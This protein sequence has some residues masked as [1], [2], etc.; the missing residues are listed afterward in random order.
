[1]SAISDTTRR[2]GWYYGW[3][4]VAVCVL[5]QV[6]ANGLAINSLSLFLRDWAAELHTQIS[7]LL[8]AMLALAFVTAGAA[9]VIGA[10]ADRYPSRLLFGAGLAGVAAFCLGV[11]LASEVWHI[12][13]LY[14]LVYPVAL[15]LSA[16]IPANAVVSRWFVKRLGLALGITAFGSGV[17]GVVLPPLIAALMPALG[18][19]AIWQV[20]AALVAFVV[21]PIAL[22]VL[23]ERPTQQ[24]GL[25]YVAGGAAHVRHG[26]GHGHGAGATAGDGLRWTD[27]LKRRNFWLLA[28][29]LVPVVAAYG[30]IHQN[31]APIAASHGFGQRYAGMLLSVF[32][33]SYIASTVLMGMASD[34]FGNRIPLAGL[35]A[36]VAA[37]AAMLGFADT[38]PALIV[39]AV[40]VGFG[41]GLW[42]LLP[43]A[44]AV[45]FG[46]VGVGRAFG[47][48]MLF[49]PIN[50]AMSLMIAK[51]KEGTG[52]Y[53]P[54]MLGL[55][56]V[57]L[58]GGLLVLLMRE[59]DGGLPTAAEKEAALE[60]P[61][62]LIP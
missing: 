15:G 24:H 53:V 39:S 4:I 18:W 19:R 59:R 40:L 5:A 31:L 41:G 16:A 47:M 27:I 2:R 29:C 45:E 8:Y 35:A 60:E 13:A 52:S 49:L 1:M 20:A 34:R 56:A 23:R 32:S 12:W 21:L 57:T 6:A 43:A 42:T 58:A 54:A 38:L 50:A 36:I 11:S 62:N 7:V 30:G 26:H 51:L 9:P 46:A 10:L 22:L 28:A 3:N 55:A 25:D 33:L 44:V 17:S 14:G 37:G 48:L 61:V